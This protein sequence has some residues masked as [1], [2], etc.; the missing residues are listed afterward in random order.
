MSRQKWKYDSTENLLMHQ[1]SN[2]C[3]TYA[4]EGSS[5]SLLL[6]NCE[7]QKNNENR[8]RFHLEKWRG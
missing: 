8:F 7:I 4:A 1:D 2:L 3:L 5:D 6:K